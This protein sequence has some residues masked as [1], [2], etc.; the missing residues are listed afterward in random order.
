MEY[1]KSASIKDFIRTGDTARG[2]DTDRNKTTTSLNADE[3]A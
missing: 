3:Y 2:N 1:S